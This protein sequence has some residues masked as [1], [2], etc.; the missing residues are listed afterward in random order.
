MFP[1]IKPTN[2]NM[3]NKKYILIIYKYLYYNSYFG[4]LCVR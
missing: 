3:N 2:Y 1:T 4:G